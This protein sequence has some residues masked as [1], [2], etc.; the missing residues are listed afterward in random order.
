MQYSSY[1]PLMD[2]IQY[3]RFLDFSGNPVTE[4]F[5]SAPRQFLRNLTKLGVP[6]RHKLSSALV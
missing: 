5:Y 1:G 4:G 3:L 2:D 6:D